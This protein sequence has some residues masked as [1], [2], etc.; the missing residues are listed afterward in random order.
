V[1]KELKNRLDWNVMMNEDISDQVS[2]IRGAVKIASSFE[3]VELVQE[4][5]SSQHPVIALQNGHH[6]RTQ[7]E[8]GTVKK[9]GTCQLHIG[10][11]KNMGLTMQRD[12]QGRC[13]VEVDYQ[14]EILREG[15][16]SKLRFI[17]PNGGKF[18]PRKN[19]L[20]YGP[21]G[22]REATFFLKDLQNIE[23]R[24]GDRDVVMVN[25]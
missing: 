1:T 24:R 8:H 6:A 13:F 23:A 3:D 7:V 17:V 12:A 22:V 20:N 25:T 21:Q 5:Y 4:I 2:Y 15:M 16:L 18:P 14:V 9:V 10:S 19:P 11:Y